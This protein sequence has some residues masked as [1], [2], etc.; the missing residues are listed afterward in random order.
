MEWS[1][2]LWVCLGIILGGVCGVGGMYL[3]NKNNVSQLENEIYDL[4]VVREALKEEIFRLDN[5]TKPKPRSK[6]RRK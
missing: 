1:I 5:Q 3:T 2:V 6:R 4:R